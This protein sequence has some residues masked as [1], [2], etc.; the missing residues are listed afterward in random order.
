MQYGR[1]ENMQVSLSLTSVTALTLRIALT[2]P[3]AYTTLR[4]ATLAVPN[5]YAAPP[6]PGSEDAVILAPFLDWVRSQNSETG[7]CCDLSDGRPLH[8]DEIR[9]NDGHY[10]VLFSTRHWPHGDNQ[11]HEVEK[12]RILLEPSPVGM[13]IAWI[14]DDLP[15]YPIGKVFCLALPGNS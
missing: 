1:D 12:R 9:I 14:N 7:Y 15:S 13:S 2:L 4:L 11:W 10:E 5:A 6:A 3:L 8:S